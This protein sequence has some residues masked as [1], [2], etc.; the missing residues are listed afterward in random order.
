MHT[1]IR[2]T[3]QWPLSLPLTSKTSVHLDYT[4]LQSMTVKLMNL[5]SFQV[6]PE[7]TT[8]Q[9]ANYFFPAKDI[10]SDFRINI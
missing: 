3:Q 8:F 9:A 6:G 5:N 10:V 4:E 1:Y 2:H 7:I